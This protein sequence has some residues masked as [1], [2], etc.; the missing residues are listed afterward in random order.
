M[1]VTHEQQGPGRHVGMSTPPRPRSLAERLA[2]IDNEES[3]VHNLH[4]SRLAAL[5]GVLQAWEYATETVVQ[6]VVGERAGW[7]IV[8]MLEAWKASL[9]LRLLSHVTPGR[10]LSSFAP[11]DTPQESWSSVVRR[12]SASSNL[13]ARALRETGGDNSGSGD[14]NSGESSQAGGDWKQRA[15]WSLVRLGEALHVLQPV[16]YLALLQWQ[17]RQLRA[18]VARRGGVSS[19]SGA[20]FFGGGWQREGR[21]RM[22]WLVALA[23]E[24][25]GLQ[26]CTLGLHQLSQQ[27]RNLPVG[28]ERKTSP[29]TPRGRT[30]IASTTDALDNARELRHRWQLV[31]LFLL[32][33]AARAA[34]RWMLAAGAATS[35]RH[36]R[37]ARWCTAALELVAA[38]ETSLWARYFR[39][40]ERLAE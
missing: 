1:R 37:F 15:A 30:S 18:A 23:L 20:G 26:L 21:R 39:S 17:Q 6:H 34:A 27:R 9:R 38:L 29:A 36:R 10:L 33:P 28:P 2:T 40:C 25:I 12:I 11:D 5:L 4:S 22:P 16:V 24:A 8:T 3:V 19:S 31:A 14:S 7:A 32:R 13:R 35:E